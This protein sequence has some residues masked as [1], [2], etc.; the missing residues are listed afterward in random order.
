[1]NPHRAHPVSPVAIVRSAIVNRQL[2][3]QLVRS[4]VVGR[5]RGS[6]MGIAWSFLS[7]LLMLTVYTIV[8]SGIFHQQWPGLPHGSTTA[9]A[10]VL[11]VGLI[12][13]GLFAE[14]ITRAP[15]LVLS[16]PNYVKRVIFPLEI[17]PWVG[18]GSAL[19]H[20]LVSFIVLI[21]AQLAINHALPWT[22]VFVPLVIVPLLLMTMGLAWF[23]AALGVFVRDISQITG[24]LVSVVMFLAPVFYPL[25]AVS[26]PRLRRWIYFNPLTMP[27][28]EARGALI[29]GLTPSL[30]HWLIAFGVGLVV[31][32]TGFWWFQRTRKGF[33]DVI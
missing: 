13:H 4:E 1:M 33:A 17:L 20:S 23:L 6:L 14:C 15:G 30:A 28:E 2:I 12:V 21:A 22:I 7:P 11:F 16:N 25:A 5:Y 19:F 9:F 27:I 18:M 8:F 26:S 24:V 10:V 31:A 29:Y 3:G 32:Q